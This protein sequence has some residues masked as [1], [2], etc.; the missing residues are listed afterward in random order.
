MND[1]LILVYALHFKPRAG[2][3]GRFDL[4][5]VFFLFWDYLGLDLRLELASFGVLDIDLSEIFL[6]A[7]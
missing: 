3:S 1:D 2:F 6:E 7:V 4:D 5:S